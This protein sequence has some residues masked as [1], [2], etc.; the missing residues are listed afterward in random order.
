MDGGESCLTGECGRL[1]SGCN[2]DC[3]G[4]DCHSLRLV[5]GR[6]LIVKG[7]GRLRLCDV[8]TC[9]DACGCAASVVEEEGRSCPLLY[10]GDDG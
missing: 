10:G 3:V 5:V 6:R 1:R 4:C 9:E 8:G 2:E 7:C